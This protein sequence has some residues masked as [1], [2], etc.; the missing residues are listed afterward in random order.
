MASP[1]H[2]YST[3][4]LRRIV[5]QIPDAECAVAHL[6]RLVS[7]TRAAVERD[8]AHP[9]RAALAQCLR[10]LEDTLAAE[11]AGAGWD[12]RALSAPADWYAKA[13]DLA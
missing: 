10:I 1:Q 13:D 2:R 9:T 12:M 4:Q 6:A 11:L 7:E 8:F 5:D 3:D